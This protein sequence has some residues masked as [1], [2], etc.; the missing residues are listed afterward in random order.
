LWSRRLESTPVCAGVDGFEEEHWVQRVR[1]AGT[2][3]WFLGTAG[4]RNRWRVFFCARAPGNSRS[5][6][7]P[8]SSISEHAWKHDAVEPLSSRTCRPGDVVVTA[9]GAEWAGRLARCAWDCRERSRASIRSCGGSAQDGFLTARLPNEERKKY[10]QK[11]A[12]KA[13]P[14]YEALNFVVP[15]LSGTEPSSSG[16]TQVGPLRSRPAKEPAIGLFCGDDFVR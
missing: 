7:A 3:A 11:G 16:L 13:L 12:R 5:T 2:Q 6:A 14:V 10:G 1:L 4:A 8:W 15:A 9:H